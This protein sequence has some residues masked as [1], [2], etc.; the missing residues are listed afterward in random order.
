MERFFDEIKD[1]FGFLREEELPAGLNPEEL[2]VMTWTGTPL[3]PGFKF[4]GGRLRPGITELIE[5]GAEHGLRRQDVV[6]WLC[7]VTT[8]FRG[9][10]RPV[11][12]LN[13]PATVLDV[14]ERSWGVVW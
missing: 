12:M 10:A 9:G 8:Y 14:A 1:E 5:L 7:V 11:D 13:D 2:L 4:E 6:T 3:Y